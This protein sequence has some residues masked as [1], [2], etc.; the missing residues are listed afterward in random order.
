M[1]LVLRSGAPDPHVEC[2]LAAMADMRLLEAD[3][4]CT[5]FGMAQPFRYVS[6][7]GPALGI[8]STRSPFAG[9]HQHEGQAVVMG[10]R[11]EP[12]LHTMRACQGHAVQVKAGVDL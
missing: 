5:K 2:A 6:A 12:E 10:P 3:H 1:I 7:Q 4:Q 9:D 11:Q 8:A